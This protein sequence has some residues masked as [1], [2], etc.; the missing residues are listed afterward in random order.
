MN[1]LALRR[2]SVV[3]AFVLAAAAGAA[4]A[5]GDGTR[6]EKKFEECATCHSLMQGQ[7]GV[8]PSLH[9]LFGRKAASVEG[10]RYSPAMSRSGITW[11]RET[12]DNFIADPQK[13]VS[14]NRMP[15]SGMT[16]A[17]ERADLIAYLQKASH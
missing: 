15:Y 6:G 2:L 4:H 11:T 1:K 16:D 7:N 17:G 13:V 3:C 8:G 10:F 14:G 9:A 12:L 5:D